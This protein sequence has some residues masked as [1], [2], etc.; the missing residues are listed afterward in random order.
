MEN[1][2]LK[3][4]MTDVFFHSITINLLDRLEK[5]PYD[6]HSYPWEAEADVYGGVERQ[7]TN[8]LP[9]GTNVS[10]GDLIKLFFE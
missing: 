6:Y 2:G 1:M 4:H 5:L 9:D 8:P 7:M 3:G 10:L